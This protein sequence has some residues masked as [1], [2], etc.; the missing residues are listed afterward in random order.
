MADVIVV[1]AGLSGLIAARELRK[2]KKEVVVLEARGRVGGRMTRRRVG[3]E[4]GVEAGWIDLG[5]QWLGDKD[6]QELNNK[7][8]RINALAK[9]LG[10]KRFEQW[11]DGATVVR[12]KGGKY[13]QGEKGIELA[14][15][16]G[17]FQEKDL[18][19]SKD[20]EAVEVLSGKLKDLAKGIDTAKPW[21][22]DKAALYDSL[23]LDRWLDESDNAYARFAVAFS[24]RFNQSGGSPREVSLLHTLFETAANPEDREPD[25][26]LLEGAAGQIPLRLYEELGGGEV[27][28]LSSRVVAIDQDKNGVTVTVLREDGSTIKYTG[29][30]V[31]VAMPP[32]LTGAIRYTPALPAERLQLVQRMPMGTIAKIACIYKEPWWRYDK[33]SGTA[34]GD[35]AMT[36]QCTADSGPR[37][38]GPGIL[39]SFIQGD[40][41]CQWSRIPDPQQRQAEVIRDLVSYFGKDAEESLVD[42]IETIW[43][44]EQFTGGAYNGYF[45]PGGWTSYG[46]VLREPQGKI[47]WAGTETSTLWYG[48]FDGAISAAER[49]AKEAIEAVDK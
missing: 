25:K 19:T 44:Q 37:S 46:R 14:A 41:L 11:K 39:T 4:K 29:K 49:A 23:T 32:F 13:L 16:I 30:A 21:K 35:E 24:S 15:K 40:K 36:V 34:M 31:I 12:Y 26:D 43:P 1:G 3:G 10:L 38:G 2:K 17:E 5:G 27:V 8:D 45:P 22:S 33:L 47:I 28:K 42:Y 18:V 9:E 48:Y 20:L 6:N 7:Q